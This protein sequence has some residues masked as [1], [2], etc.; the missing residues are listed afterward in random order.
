MSIR[1]VRPTRAARAITVSGPTG[2]HRLELAGLDDRDVLD[3]H[4][5]SR[6]EPPPH[7]LEQRAG[8]ALAGTEGFVRGLRSARLSASASRPIVGREVAR[9]GC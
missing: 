7:P 2:L 9:S 3:R 4:R 1:R 8:A 5:R 6:R